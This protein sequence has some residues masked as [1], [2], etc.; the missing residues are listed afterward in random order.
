MSLDLNKIVGAVGKTGFKLEYKIGNILRANG[1]QLISNR[2]YIDDLQGTVR[3]IDLLAYKVSIVKDISVYTVMIVSCKK[4]ET[5]AWTLFSRSVAKNDPN[6]N[7]R[8]FKGWSSHPAINYYMAKADWSE[9]Y[10]GKMAEA[11]PALFFRP[12]VDVFAFQEINKTSYAPQNDKSIFLS[13]T[14][15]MKAQAYEMGNLENRHGANKRFYQFNLVSLID[16]DISRVFFDGEDVRASI[17]ES[18]DYLCRYIINK[19]EETARIKFVTA[20]A[21]PQLLS[22]Y[23]TLHTENCNVVGDAYDNFY[24]DAFRD[25]QKASVLLADFDRLARPAFV[26]SLIRNRKP[27]DGLSTIT[28]FWWESRNILQIEV[29]YSSID[30]SLIKIWNEDETLIKRLEAILAS[31]YHYTGSF[32]VDELIPF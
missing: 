9:L 6:Y 27:S 3:E 2:S 4:S 20:N 22:E 7:W 17:V 8:P 28:L 18:E 14:S 12:E 24:A 31:V 32:E 29:D 30:A 13:I 19:H 25:S 1:W 26:S 15:L 10:H 23:S 11:C 16:S 21:F 5:N